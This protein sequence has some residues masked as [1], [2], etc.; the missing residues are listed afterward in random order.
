MNLF[1]K[2]RD[3]LKNLTN[4]DIVG[5]TPQLFSSKKEK[6]EEL[7]NNLNKQFEVMGMNDFSRKKRLLQISTILQ[8]VMIIEKIK[9]AN[10]YRLDT[11]RDKA[12][13]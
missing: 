5:Y 4:Y 3:I 12:E 13:Q 2:C 1:T 11:R 6:I 9:D 8:C 7:G 10:S